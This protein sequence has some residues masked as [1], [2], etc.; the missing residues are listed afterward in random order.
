MPGHDG[1]VRVDTAPFIYIIHFLRD[2][3]WRLFP[4]SYWRAARFFPALTTAGR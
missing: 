1:L 2:S 4:D 3:P